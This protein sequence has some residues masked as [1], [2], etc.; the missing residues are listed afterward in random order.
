MV[1]MDGAVK[2][3]WFGVRETLSK[4]LSLS[5]NNELL[6]QIFFCSKVEVILPSSQAV[7][8]VQRA[9]EQ[10]LTSTWHEGLCS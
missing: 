7:A 3:A 9:T 6:Q 2:R 8:A 1:S 10:S 4:M 5:L